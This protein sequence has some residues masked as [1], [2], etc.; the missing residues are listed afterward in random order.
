VERVAQKS[1]SFAEAREWETEQYR[2]MSVEERRSIARALRHRY[3][4]DDNPD[5]RAAFAG[6]RRKSRER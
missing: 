1:R 4:G 3:Y 2:S 6:V 5:V